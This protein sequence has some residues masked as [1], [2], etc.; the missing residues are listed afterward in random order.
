MTMT[1]GAPARE[2]AAPVP[3]LRY[4]V[5][6]RPAGWT[7]EN[8]EIL[9]AGPYQYRAD[10]TAEARRLNAEL[11]AAED[12]AAAHADADD[13]DH[14]HE[15][16][17]EDSR[18]KTYPH[19]VTRELR[20]TTESVR[21]TIQSFVADEYARV[22]AANGGARALAWVDLLA[23]ARWLGEEVTAA[24]TAEAARRDDAEAAR[25]AAQP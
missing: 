19:G 11:R 18:P 12:A 22:L 10:A 4:R 23:Q 17:E 6:S 1:T 13:H 15:K 25:R 5:R 2:G 3:A 7:V 14:D 8:T 20:N 21:L 24:F 9:A 16:E